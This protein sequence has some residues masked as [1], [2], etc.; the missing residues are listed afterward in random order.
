MFN[1]NKYFIFSLLSLVILGCGNESDNNEGPSPQEKIAIN[2]QDLLSFSPTKNTQVIDLRQKVTAE[3]NQNLIIDNIESIDNNCDFNKN[4]INGLT[5][6]VTTDG[7]DV[8]RFK[9]HVKPQSSKYTGT[10]EGM[11]QVVVTEDYTKGDFLPPV[12]RTITESGSLILDAKD[13]L[14]ESG[15]EIDPTSVYLTGE[16]ASSDIGSF[17]ADS[18]SITYQAPTETTGTVRIFYTEIDS[19][20]NIARPGVAYVAI[21]QQGNYNPIALNKKLEPHSLTGANINID[22]SDYISDLDKDD[23]LQL[24]DVRAFLG[25]IK[26]DST[27]SFIYTPHLTGTEVLTYIISD[28]NGGYGIGTLSFTVTPY[29]AIIDNVQKLIFTPPL[30]IEQISGINGIYTDT[31][32]EIGTTGI[33]GKYPTF[34]HVLADAY[35]TTKGM[36]IASLTALKNMRTNILG[37]KPI[38]T[39]K[40]LWHSGKPYMTFEGTAIS[41]NTGMEDTS[42]TDGY[43]SC[44]DTIT[45]RSWTFVDKYYGAKYNRATR[46]Y[47][48]AKTA[49]GASVFLDSDKYKLTYQVDTI[50]VNG[51]LIDPKLAD[52]FIQVNIAANSITIN[53]KPGS[54][55]DAVNV[56]LRISDPSAP[57][58][59]TKVILGITTCPSDVTEPPQT[60]RLGCI[61]PLHGKNNEQFTVAL[62]NN[63]LETTGLSPA[64]IKGLGKAQI[65]SGDTFIRALQWSNSGTSNVDREHWIEVIDNSCDVLNR[66]KLNGRDN[67]RSASDAIVPLKP[68]EKDKNVFSLSISEHTQASSFVDW[69][70]SI[71]H[72]SLGAD[73]FYGL[74]FV[75]ND[76]NSLDYVNQDFNSEIF[77]VQSNKNQTYKNTYSYPSCWSKN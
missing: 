59:T 25:T 41:L 5:F 50:N 7:A 58:S 3:D 60:D 52:D 13:L 65:G 72:Y 71:D 34:D 22:I 24:I 51:T 11:V 10:S 70:A 21:G 61:I 14:V 30:I 77:Q 16:T 29:E 2:A 35:C 26:I 63:M 27:N 38:Y 69:L 6:K 4:D 1:I 15:F 56:T 74:G 49:S 46:V 36:N 66:I 19:I 28:H 17:T 57:T 64:D 76:P 33:I 20:N 75:N 9:Y 32:Y 31:F 8:C 42:A 37:N 48:S 18:S 47:L 40:Y 43:F 39:T 44:A 55:G 54:T 62:T 67:W 45:A 73:S 68:A 12:S 53:K 23:I